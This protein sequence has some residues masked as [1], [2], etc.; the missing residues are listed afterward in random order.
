MNINKDRA[1]AVIEYINDSEDYTFRKFAEDNGLM[2]GAL[3]RVDDLEISC[4]FHEDAAP[5]LSFNDKIHAFHC[6]SCGR[7]GSYLD[8]LQQYDLEV[9][10]LH[11]TF[12]G[13]LNSLLANDHKMQA[14]LGFNTIYTKED[15]FSLDSIEFE[16]IRCQNGSKL[17]SS[18]LELADL[19]KKKK[20][21]I[22]RIKLFILLMQDKFSVIDVYRMV[23]DSEEVEESHSSKNYSINKILGE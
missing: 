22:E 7:H 14:S 16:R 6:F 20:L 17:P 23:F 12:Y 13:K 5:S 15:N 2:E 4:V 1:K 18:Y 8:F 19:I 10:G 9:L 21:P 11:R 3:E